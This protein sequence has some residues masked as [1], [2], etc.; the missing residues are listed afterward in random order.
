MHVDGQ[1]QTLIGGYANIKGIGPKTCD[2]ILENAPYSSWDGLKDT[3]KPAM[4]QKIQT[5]QDAISGLIDTS[6]MIPLASWAPVQKTHEGLI[7]LR[8]NGTFS[9]SYEL[10]FGISV[11]GDVVVGGYLTWMDDDRDKLLFLIEDEYGGVS[12]RVPAKMLSTL[13]PKFREFKLGD[14]IAVRG[15]WTGETLFA[16]DGTLA[17]RH[18]KPEPIKPEKKPRKKKEAVAA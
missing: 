10:P 11:N 1:E 14:F 3:L 8:T 13:G 12:C 4:R 9:A 16:K 2:S 7:Q 18:V 6:E 15:W 5:C 17:Y